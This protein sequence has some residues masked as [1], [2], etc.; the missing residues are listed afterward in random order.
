[1][2]TRFE[3]EGRTL[4]QVVEH[5]GAAVSYPVVA[6]PRV[7]RCNLWTSWCVTFTRSETTAVARSSYSQS[8]SAFVATMCARIPNPLLAGGCVAAGVAI[9]LSLRN[10]FRNASANGRCAQIQFTSGGIP[11]RWKSVSC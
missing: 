1:M 6:D 4:T 11:F 7:F 2:P 10:T 5:R 9:G 3:V 8:L